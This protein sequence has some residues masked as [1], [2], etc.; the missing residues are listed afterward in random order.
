M[1]KLSLITLNYNGLEV[2]KNCVESVLAHCSGVDWEWLI[3]ENGSTDGS[4]EYL[5]ALADPRIRI[6]ERDNTG[7][8]SSMNNA[9]AKHAKGQYLCF[10]NNDTEATSDFLTPML[11]MLENDPM[12]GVV[13]SVLKYPNGELQS[14]GILFSADIS[15][16][17][18]SIHLLNNF[19]VYK[20]LHLKDREYDAVTGACFMMSKKDFDWVWGFDPS[21]S[22]AYED[23]DLCLKIKHHI[24]KR[25]VTCKGAVLTHHE[26]YSKANPNLEKNFQLFKKRWQSL[27]KPNLAKYYKDACAYSRAEHVPEMTF[28]VCTNDLSCLNEC[29]IESLS[30]NQ[31]N[32]SLVVVYNMDNRY[33]AAQALNFG[34]KQSPTEFVICCHQDVI[35]NESWT[36]RFLKEISKYPKFGVAGLAGVKRIAPPYPKGVPVNKAEGIYVN[37]Y[38]ELTYPFKGTTH[39]YGQFPEGRVEIVDELALII[40]KSGPLRFDEY[41]LTNFHVYGVDISL[42]SLDKGYENVI[43]NLPAFHKSDGASSLKTGMDAYWREFKKVREKWRAKFPVIVTTTG[44]WSHTSHETFIKPETTALSE[45]PLPK[46]KTNMPIEVGLGSSQSFELPQTLPGSKIAWYLND[47]LTSCEKPR[48][49]FTATNKGVHHL[50]AVFTDMRGNMGVHEWLVNSVEH[51]NENH[52][53]GMQQNFHSHTVGEIFGTKRVSQEFTPDKNKLCRIDLFLGT[54][55]RLNK[56]TID[57]TITN[58]LNG[59]VLRHAS[60]PAESVFDNDWASFTFAPLDAAGQKLIVN[61][62]SKNAAPGNALTAYFINHTFVFGTLFYNDRKINGC[63]TFRLYYER[64]AEAPAHLTSEQ[65]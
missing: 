27:V 15:P 14:A 57:L 8:F 49:L 35:F 60:L 32:Y 44:Y 58:D 16:V 61:V 52:V 5:Q 28:V 17:N 51:K 36:K 25:V 50:K 59:D 29:V 43:L 18:V 53:L 34:I 54:F 47:T 11:I 13:G 46:S 65:A 21:Y 23:V 37:C 1:P 48:Y 22:W 24:N 2:L 19:P 6:F 64:E 56:C 9:L 63:L 3:A 33:N 41:T 4:L 31:Q 55:K 20:Y 12:I 30:R 10:L 40:R 42:Q 62:D 26:S 38:G 45:A 39:K 7:N